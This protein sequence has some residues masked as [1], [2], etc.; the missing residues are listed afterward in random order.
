[1]LFR[2]LAILLASRPL[3]GAAAPP[4]ALMAHLTTLAVAADRGAGE[5]RWTPAPHGAYARVLA[6]VAAS[7][8]P[9]RRESPMNVIV[10]ARI[11]DTLSCEASRP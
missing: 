3:N 9:R 4:S 2:S 6:A 7:A 10:V 8:V 1:M 5:K 11:A